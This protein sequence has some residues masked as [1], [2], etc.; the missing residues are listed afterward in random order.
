MSV[1][2]PFTTGS[3]ER[4]PAPP[5]ASAAPE[6]AARTRP[7]SSRLLRSELWLIFGRRRNWAG[8]A[9]LAAVP[10]LIAIAVKV[11]PPGGGGGG[12]NFFASI[13]SNGLFV[14]LA[15]LTVELPLFLPLAVA[16][17][18]ADAIAGEANLGT[19]RYLLTVPVGRTRM[20]VV[21]YAAIVI[22]A[23]AA[24]VLVAAVGAILGLVLF[25]GGPVTTLSGTQV[26]FAPAVLRLLGVCGYIAV[27]LSAL[28]AIGLFV[29]TLT[30]QP[31]G[32]TVAIVTVNVL[33][34][35]LDS[36]PQVDWLHPYLLTH[37]WMNYGDLLR[38]PV[39][40]SGIADGLLA[41]AAYALVFWAAAWARFSGRDVTG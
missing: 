8:L 17:I 36:I 39:S 10:T 33:S 41:A 15:A 37:Y 27:G 23:V 3:P 28:G 35:I 38:D 14:A 12:P 4:P 21:K 20:L 29:S 26:P 34:F 13:T 19:L 18:S 6:T 2:E 11:S 31:I 25:G 24:T 22:F 32:A 9:V 1:A 7:V 30:E 5:V 40:W 16:A